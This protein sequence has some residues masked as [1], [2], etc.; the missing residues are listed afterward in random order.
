MPHSNYSDFSKCY[1]HTLKATSTFRSTSHMPNFFYVFP[2]H[3]F[4]LI[5]Q[6]FNAI[7]AAICYAIRIFFIRIIW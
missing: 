1:P 4:A 5:Y 6:Y 3:T 7:V 2:I